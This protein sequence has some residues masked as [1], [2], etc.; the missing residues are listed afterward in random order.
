[1]EN[2]KNMV[3]DEKGKQIVDKN[4]KKYVYVL[5]RDD[6][7]VSQQCVQTAHAAMLA[8]S[9]HGGL[10]EDT[11]LVVLRVNDEAQLLSYFDKTKDYGI[12]A[13]KFFEPDYN[14]CY[15]ALS[16]APIDRESGRLF[17]KLKL[18]KA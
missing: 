13:E 3:F 12:K 6:L 10:S 8:I 15:S 17:K 5:V 4:E 18:W 9:K 11:R 1:M 7:T 16:T 2:L 14:I